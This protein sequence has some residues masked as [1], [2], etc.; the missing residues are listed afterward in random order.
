MI[1]LIFLL[2]ITAGLLVLLVVMGRRATSPEG[3]AQALLDARYALQTLRFGLLP[4]EFVGHIFDTQDLEY[5]TAN[6]SPEIQQLL[7]E[8]RK[9]ILLAWASQVRQQVLSLHDFHFGH[10][11]HFVQLSLVNEI[12][13][14]WEFSTLRV[15]CRAFCFLVY[16]RGPYGAP[17]VAGKMVSTA[18]RLCALSERSLAFLNPAEG[19][20]NV[21]ESARGSAAV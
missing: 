20:V 9:R 13:L 14:A 2:V 21:D 15:A 7:L 16:F 3:S 18:D 6:A 1:A 11:R 17:K 4:S 8:D 10:S 12:A 5:V 19:R